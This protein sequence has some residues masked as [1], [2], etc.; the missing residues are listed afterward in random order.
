MSHKHSAIIERI[1]KRLAENA[2]HDPYRFLISASASGPTS[3]AVYLVKGGVYVDPAESR[4]VQLWT[5]YVP[6]AEAAFQA[7]THE[8][9][10]ALAG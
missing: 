3:V 4:P 10:G 9:S 8:I 2:G 1:A 5:L 6:D 7:A